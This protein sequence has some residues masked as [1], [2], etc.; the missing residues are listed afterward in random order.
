MSRLQFYAGQEFLRRDRAQQARGEGKLQGSHLCRHWVVVWWWG[1]DQR[2]HCTGNWR[3]FSGC[4]CM[5]HLAAESQNGNLDRKR[6]C[7]GPPTA[8]MTICLLHV[9]TCLFLYDPL[10]VSVLR[11]SARALTEASA[12]REEMIRQ[13]G[14]MFDLLS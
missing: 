14:E 8:A 3:E 5:E 6:C 7:R 4:L 2:W 13:A 12:A 10:V 1:P 9:P 11:G